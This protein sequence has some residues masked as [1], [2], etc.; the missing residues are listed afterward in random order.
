MPG[1]SACVHLQPAPGAFHQG[2]EKARAF[3]VENKDITDEIADKVM[4]AVGFGAV[5]VA[6][7]SDPAEIS[8]DSE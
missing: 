4:S 6:S 8:D 3:L 1:H 5:V 2:K 7:D